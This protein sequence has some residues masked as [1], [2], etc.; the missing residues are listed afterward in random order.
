MK[1]CQWANLKVGNNFT[2]YGI[3]TNGE[4]WKFYRL[5]DNGEVWETLLSGIGEMGILLGRLRG[6]FQVCE[7]NLIGGGHG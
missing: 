4:G 2:V 1:A 3:V 6:F 5:Q 7:Q